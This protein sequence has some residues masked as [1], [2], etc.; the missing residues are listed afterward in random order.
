MFR[1][2]AELDRLLSTIRDDEVADAV[3]WMFERALRRTA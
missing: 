2:D 3:T 1:V